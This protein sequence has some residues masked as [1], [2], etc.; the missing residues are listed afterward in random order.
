MRPYVKRRSAWVERVM[1]KYFADWPEYDEQVS[2]FDLRGYDE[3]TVRSLGIGYFTRLMPRADVIAI[4]GD[5]LLVVEFDR[6]MEILHVSRL[7]RYVDA[8]RHDEARPDW[9]RRRIFATYVTP[10]YDAR[11][12]DECRRL[13]FQYIVEPEPRGS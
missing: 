5:E 3:K 4:R 9:R 11:I 2:I 12:E 7:E 1:S 8:I 10:G 13:G 6:Q